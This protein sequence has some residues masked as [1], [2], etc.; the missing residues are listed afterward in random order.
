[1]YKI[2][3]IDGIAMHEWKNLGIEGNVCTL[4]C[5]FSLEMMW[6]EATLT[7]CRSKPS[8]SVSQVK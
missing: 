7:G 2:Y 3:C 6:T 5:M 1:M 4:I 8:F